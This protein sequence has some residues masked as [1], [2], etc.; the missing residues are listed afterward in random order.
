[1]R[2]TD[3]KIFFFLDTGAWVMACGDM[4]FLEKSFWRRTISEF[5]TLG[6]QTMKVNVLP[7]INPKGEKICEFNEIEKKISPLSKF[8]NDA[9]AHQRKR[10][11]YKLIRRYNKGLRE[12]KVVIASG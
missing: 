6:V 4:I 5:Q 11:E 7:R 8:K 1:M 2:V 12:E 10:D 3:T 9:S